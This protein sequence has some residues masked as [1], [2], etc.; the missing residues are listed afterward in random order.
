MVIQN[1]RKNARRVA[2]ADVAGAKH[3]AELLHAGVMERMIPLTKRSTMYLVPT[4]YDILKNRRVRF[5]KRENEVTGETELFLPKEKLE[6]VIVFKSSTFENRKYY[7][8]FSDSTESH[9]RIVWGGYCTE[10]E[11]K[12]LIAPYVVPKK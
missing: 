5:Q 11:S 9:T 7:L 8:V 2:L 12:E 4:G 6:R 1:R 10:L 3:E